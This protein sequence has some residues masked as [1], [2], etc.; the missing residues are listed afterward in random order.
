MGG[1]NAVFAYSPAQAGT[2]SRRNV[3]AYGDLEVTGAD[4]AWTLGAA[5]RMED[6]EDFGTTTNGKLSGRVGFVRGSVSTGFRAPTPGQQHGLHIQSWFDPTVGDLVNNAVIPSISPVA[7]LRGGCAARAREIDQLHGRRRVRERS[8]HAHRR[9]LPHRRVRPDRHHEQLH[10]DAGRDRRGRGRGLRGGRRACGTTASS[11][12]PSATTSQ[13]IDVVSTWTPLALRGNTVV[14]AVFNH[15]DTAVTDNAKGLLDGRRR[16]EYAYALPRIRWNAGV[17]QRLGRASLLGR[18]SYYSGWYDYD[19]GRGTVF[20]PAGGLEQGFFDG[21]PIV[22]LELSVPPRT[23][24]DAGRRADR[25]S[26][27]PTRRYRSSPMP[28]ASSTAS[29]CPGATAAPTTTCAS[30]TAGAIERFAKRDATMASNAADAHR[31][32]RYEPDE[33]PGRPAVIDG[34]REPRPSRDCRNPG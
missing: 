18:L 25:T 33:R 17:T 27:T 26:S 24:H 8:V 2:W 19:S 32:V 20:D 6:F 29:T 15:T 10:A 34:L 13:G 9:L 28:S 4:D 16:A 22:D 5:V 3:A 12:T 11:P 1:S 23:G 30:V 31:D 7:L 21:R 14:S